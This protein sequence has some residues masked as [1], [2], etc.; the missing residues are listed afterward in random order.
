MHML[1]LKM[2]YILTCQQLSYFVSSRFTEFHLAHGKHVIEIGQSVVYTSDTLFQNEYI[3]SV[4]V[5]IHI[6]PHICILRVSQGI[7]LLF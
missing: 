4:I 7:I 3:L 5:E 2:L 1:F 6:S